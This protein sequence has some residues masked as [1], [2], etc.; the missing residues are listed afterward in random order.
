VTVVSPRP[1]FL[2]TPLL[3]GATVGTVHH[4]NIIEPIRNFVAVG[5]RGAGAAGGASVSYVQA[6]AL[7]VDPSNHKIECEL[8]P[9]SWGETTDVPATRPSRFSGAVKV[10]APHPSDRTRVTLDYDKLVIAVGAQPATFGT[11]GVAEH[12][13]FLKELDHSAVL[14]QRLL[15]CLERASALVTTNAR[16]EVDKLLHFVIVG[17]GPTGVELS[18]ELSDFIRTDVKRLFPHLADRVKVTLL[19]AAPRILGPFAE[20]LSSYAVEHLEEVGVSVQ[21]GACVTKVAGPHK[22][23]IRTKAPDGKAVE[24]DLDFGAL[25][26]AAGISTRPL[27][28]DLAA[29]LGKDAG[30]DSRRGLVV[31]E[32]LRVKG[33]EDGSVFAI[34]DCAVSG[35]PPTAQVAAQQGKW[36]GRALRDGAVVQEAE[37]FSYDDKGKMAYVGKHAAVVEAK[38]GPPKL[39]VQDHF[40]WR[41][42]HGAAPASDNET[43]AAAEL[44]GGAAFAFWRGTYFSKLMSPTNRVAVGVDWFRAE[45]FGRD[46]TVHQAQ[47]RRR[48]TTAK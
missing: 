16:G 17:G 48:E 18:A 10:V 14:Q 21:T 8:P 12:A 9:A 33:V 2:Y 1:F 5:G 35:L 23:T 47:M 4:G 31:D 29:S 27:V 37:P 30:Q 24:T 46:V 32:R 20:S 13:F 25:V 45:M 39:K 43:R 40:W 7:S 19:E 26:W 41:S 34:G 28:R 42:L 36:L 44:T 11:P 15:E 38:L 3:A 22:A 6:S